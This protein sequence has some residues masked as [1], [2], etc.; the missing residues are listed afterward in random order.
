MKVNSF[1]IFISD[2]LEIL[3][4]IPLQVGNFGVSYSECNFLYS[5]V[6]IYIIVC[7]YVCTYN[8]LNRFPR[9]LELESNMCQLRGPLKEKKKKLKQNGGHLQA[10]EKTYSDLP[11]TVPR[12]DWC[13]MSP[14]AVKFESESIKVS[15][16]FFFN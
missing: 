13:N 10:A 4:Q 6:L 16:N 3:G 8:C 1:D 2:C 12:T 5:T 11:L 14:C 7:M 15:F 9:N